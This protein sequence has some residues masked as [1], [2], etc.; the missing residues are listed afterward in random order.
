MPTPLQQV[1]DE[2]TGRVVVS[3]ARTA[4]GMWGSFRGL[5]LRKRI[6][7][8]FGLVFRP[9]KGIHTQFMRFPIDL[10]YFDE[11]QRVTKIREAMKPWRFDFTHAAGVIEM[12]P[13]AARAA[14]IRAGDRLRFEPIDGAAASSRV[15]PDA[16]A[17]PARTGGRR[18]QFGG[19][20]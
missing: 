7:D 9:A 14:D 8:G 19:T 20:T 6:P 2:R 18:A 17:E 15:P 12:N 16:H 3:E 5:M 13:G 4:E 10:V 1:I 11:D